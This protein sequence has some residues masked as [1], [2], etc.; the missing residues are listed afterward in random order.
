MN[1]AELDRKVAAALG[2]GAANYSTDWSV[3]GPIIEQELIHLSGVQR[4][5]G[6]EWYAY[7]RLGERT[8][9]GVGPTPLIAAMRCVVARNIL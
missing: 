6:C 7:S 8:A 3:G 5:T 9:K 4:T 1:T 2:L